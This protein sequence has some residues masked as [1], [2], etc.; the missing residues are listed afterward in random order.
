MFPAWCS[1]AEMSVSLPTLSYS[2]EMG[3]MDE[4]LQA[5]GSGRASGN[6]HCFSASQQRTAAFSFEFTGL[7]PFP[8]PQDLEEPHCLQMTNW[9]SFLL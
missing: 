5:L 2:S 1:T 9:G 6:R 7:W 4:S 8:V 3:S